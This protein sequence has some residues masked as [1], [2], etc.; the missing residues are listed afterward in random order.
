M[1]NN[2]GNI[3]NKVFIKNN[4]CNMNEVKNYKHNLYNRNFQSSGILGQNYSLKSY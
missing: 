2:K 4:A 1:V 3:T